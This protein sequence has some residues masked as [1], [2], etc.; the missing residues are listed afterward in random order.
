MAFTGCSTTGSGEPQTEV[1]VVN[2]LGSADGNV[3]SESDESRIADVLE[4]AGALADSGDYE[5]A[6]IL[7]KK[8]LKEFPNSKALEN[9][10]KK[11]RKQI[12]ASTEV[13]ES[14]NV[15][16]MDAKPASSVPASVDVH[17]PF[18]GIWVIGT[19]DYTEAN[20]KAQE[21]RNNGFDGQVYVT[22]DWSN[23]NSERWFV[24]TAG[25]YPNE[26][27]AKEKLPNVQALYKDAYV[28]YSGSWKGY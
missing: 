28:K 13:T 21:V 1:Q 23:L 18:Y 22:T 10:R 3:Y 24:V 5:A 4:D 15:S 2:N 25:S 11:Y 17:Q 14:E 12:R 16:D 26:E 6:L 27:S 9:M 7:I 19:K 20:N 8:G